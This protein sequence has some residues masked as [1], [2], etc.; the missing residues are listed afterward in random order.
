M[1]LEFK[2]WV[3]QEWGKTAW[4]VAKGA[5]PI[6]TQASGLPDPTEIG[7]NTHGVGDGVNAAFSLAKGA[8]NW[9]TALTP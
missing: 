7:L 5:L 2:E 6:V 4:T 9:F 3:A 1:K 8:F